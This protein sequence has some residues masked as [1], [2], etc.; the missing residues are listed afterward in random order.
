MALTS[1]DETDLLLPLYS[2]AQEN[3]PFSTFLERLGRRTGADYVGLILR[4]T[5]SSAMEATEFFAG[6]DLRKRAREAGIGELHTLEAL[7]HDRLRPGRVYSVSEFVDHDPEYR[8]ERE[9]SVERIGIV[10][11]RVVRVSEVAG[12]GAW[13]VIARG[14]PCTA[15]DSALLSNLAPYVG[16]AMTNFVLME[17]QR[18]E[19]AMNAEGLGRSGVG[20][21]LF[22]PQA[23]V[24]AYDSETARQLR[25][26]AGITLRSG[27]RLRNIGLQAERELAEAASALAGDPDAP[28]RAAILSEE[29]RIEAQLESANS[30]RLA[31]LKAPAMLALCRFPRSRPPERADRL[32]LLFD[33]PRREAELAIALSDGLSIAEAA[34]EMELTIETARNYSKRLYAKLGVRGQAELVRL[35][36]ESSAVLA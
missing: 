11:E 31:G 14:K 34:E 19:A 15:A 13:L 2:G 33:L 36:Y 5:G 28:P 7:H 27:E 35:V 8:A 30:V 6:I 20:W 29:P 3:P 21:I 26:I 25:E 22:D 9:R 16:A 24:L 32:A 1:R 23:R 12:I 10:D 4:R 17:S 18:I